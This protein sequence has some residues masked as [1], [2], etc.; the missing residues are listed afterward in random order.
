MENSEII[1]AP[2]SLKIKKAK[3]AYPMNFLKIKLV[4]YKLTISYG[5][6][7]VLLTLLAQNCARQGSF[8]ISS[9]LNPTPHEE[10]DLCSPG[11]EVTASGGA[12][13]NHPGIEKINKVNTLNLRLGDRF[14]IEHLLKS[15]F[16]KPD[17]N[18]AEERV[19]LSILNQEVHAFP[20]VFGGSDFA[21]GPE[22]REVTQPNHIGF[23][24][25]RSSRM[26]RVCGRL[27]ED[28]Q[29]L[30]NALMTLN[31]DP[32]Q[33]QPTEI[34]D[35]ILLSIYWLFFEGFDAPADDG[36]TLAELAAAFRAIAHGLRDKGLPNREIWQYLVFSVCISPDWQAI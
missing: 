1:L 21:V 26:Q 11:K 6:I 36:Q 18:D 27:V 24:A 34:G 28:R 14:Y 7:F 25:T 32:D 5:I 2:K 31:I 20:G 19:F 17:S 9:S 10:L 13:L 33:T 4:K 3:E 29:L 15:V 23:T 16:L 30:A 12:C 22:S 8:R 35:D